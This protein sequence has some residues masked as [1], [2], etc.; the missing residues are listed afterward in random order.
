MDFVI[1]NTSLPSLA[2]KYA[3]VTGG[4]SGIGLA[5]CQILAEHHITCVLI[6]DTNPPPQSVK[7]SEQIKYEPC[8]VSKWNDLR[9]AFSIIPRLDFVFANAGCSEDQN[10]L[11]YDPAE[12]GS[13]LEPS[14]TVVDTNFRGAFNAAVL[15]IRAMRRQ[16]S[17]G[18]IVFT[19]S[20]T[21]YS[22]ERGLALYGAQKLAVIGLV[23]GWRHSLIKDNITVNAVAPAC[24]VTGLI[25][26]EVGSRLA[27][28]GLQVSS[29]WHVGLALVYSATAKENTRV[30][31]YGKELDKDNESTS[32]R[33]NGRVVLTI[34]NRY[35]EIEERIERLK[36]EWFGPQ[37]LQDTRVGQCVT[38]GMF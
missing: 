23:R 30:E 1:N 9:R 21:A 2:G 16:R 17:G 25:P 14:Q 20:A 32:G 3:I 10:P 34:G 19:S 26:P 6:L 15:G 33:W 37:N 8:D 31:A 35:T 38:E 36:G 18:S 29:A 27:K 5:C 12:D 7:L 13:D 22:S 4:A 24:T 28:S 11:D